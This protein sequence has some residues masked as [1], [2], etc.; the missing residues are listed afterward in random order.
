MDLKQ[1]LA[2]I[3]AN[4]PSND[5]IA[6]KKATFTVESAQAE[7]ERSVTVNT[8]SNVKKDVDSAFQE[9]KEYEDKLTKESGQ[10]NS[11]GEYIQGTGDFIKSFVKRVEDV[12][13]KMA[14]AY[15]EMLTK[16]SGQGSEI[17][18]AARTS[19]LV[20]LGRT[21]QDEFAEEFFPSILTPEQNQIVF[22]YTIGSYIKNWKNDNKE[23]LA[24]HDTLVDT[25]YVQGNT[26]RLIPEF[27][28][29]NKYLNDNIKYN[30]ENG[31]NVF[32][33][34]PYKFDTVIDVMDSCTD[35]ISVAGTK[36]NVRTIAPNLKLHKVFFSSAKL[37]AEYGIADERKFVFNTSVMHANNATPVFNGKKE[38]FGINFGKDAV[39]TLPLSAVADGVDQSLFGATYPDAQVHFTLRVTVDGNLTTSKLKG[40]VSEFEVV[41]MTV[42]GNKLFAGDT[43]FDTIFAEI[44]DV[45]PVGFE[46]EAFEA[47]GD[48]VNEGNVLTLD[49]DSQ[50]YP[51]GYKQP[52]TVKGPI[53]NLYNPKNDMSELAQ[54]ITHT[55]DK[56]SVDAKTL[57]LSTLNSVKL[58]PL[59]TSVVTG[60][61]NRLITPTV[62]ESAVDIKAQI[63][64]METSNL[65]TSVKALLIN[66]IKTVAT[67]MFV[68][69]KYKAIF[70]RF[71]KNRKMRLSV[72]IDQRLETWLPTGKYELGEIDAYVVSTVDNR[73]DNKIVMAFTSS[74]PDR[75]KDIDILGL[76]FN[77]YDTTV[78][79]QVKKTIAGSSIE[80]VMAFPKY[81]HIVMC[82]VLS[83]INVSGIDETFV[84]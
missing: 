9:L 5:D 29:G 62:I 4:M 18:I 71:Y 66:V 45:K 24:I 8:D 14:N 23:L 42:G 43:A 72:G 35:E 55:G 69:S 68:A 60:I 56:A 16:E 54:F 80:A 7:F 41:S 57:L 25:S 65:E 76:G 64:N 53:A 83:E 21:N 26:L 44:K 40:H 3:N 70:N 52:L 17:A 15:D 31:I 32:E 11:D 67:K 84:G 13:G 82:S 6:N 50:T 10:V 34:A 22:K 1:K 38:D 19:M 73:F 12:S 78:V 47:N 36:N 2:H 81:E 59:A 74:E 39:F 51:I 61:G 48:V 58:S 63:A 79:T 49:N 27:E 77:A 20:N 46:L 33:T 28:A 75:N 30:L 37:P